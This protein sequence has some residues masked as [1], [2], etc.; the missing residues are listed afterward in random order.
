MKLKK[1]KSVLKNE[2]TNTHDLFALDNTKKKLQ[3]I[4]KRLISLER[5]NSE[6][7]RQIH[8]SQSRHKFFSNKKNYNLEVDKV[9]NIL[10]YIPK[11]NVRF[12]P[13]DIAS[14]GESDNIDMT[15]TGT[16]FSDFSKFNNF[17]KYQDAITENNKSFDLDFMNFKT[18]FILKFSKNSSLYEKLLSIIDGLSYINKNNIYENVE[19]IKN[20]SEKKEILLFDNRAY[21]NQN[22]SSLKENVLLFYEFECSWQK[23]TENLLKEL[24]KNIE[25]NVSALKRIKDQGEQIMEM[26]KKIDEL[27][28]FIKIN[29]IHT[30]ISKHNKTLL[31]IKEAKDEYEKKENLRLIELFNM[32]NQ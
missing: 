29:D 28:D 14:Y 26:N 12:I 32:E 23:L 3:I 19:K 30:K 10:N 18:N 4:P 25:S 21:K 5:L 22:F 31:T 20:T 13:H 6:N 11:G 1:F 24:K 9:S 2:E 17:S 15:K 8:S 16:K 27:K 7:N